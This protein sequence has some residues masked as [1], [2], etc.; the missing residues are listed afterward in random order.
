MNPEERFDIFF[1][2][3]IMQPFVISLLF[4]T[5]AVVEAALNGPCSVGGTP[6][7]CIRTTSC[8]NSGG[9]SHNGYCPSD[10]TDIKCCTKTSC[11]NGGNC[12]W[13]SQCSGTTVPSMTKSPSSNWQWINP[14]PIFQTF[15]LALPTSCAAKAPEAHPL[16]QLQNANPMLSSTVGPSW[17]S[18]LMPYI[19]FGAMQKNLATMGL[20]WPWTL[21]LAT[22][23]LWAGKL[24]SG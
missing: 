14:P 3:V 5:A 10:P 2:P 17:I 9:T 8:S 4:V 16:F 12:R 20:D 19:Q 1:T 6:G 21:W 11:G 15:A 18:F 24:Q 22:E 7:V 23:T 13:T